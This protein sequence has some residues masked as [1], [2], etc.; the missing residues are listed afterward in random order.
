MNTITA[1]AN[2]KVV[3]ER[4]KGVTHVYDDEGNFLGIIIPQAQADAALYEEAK[5]LFDPKEFERRMREEAGQGITW[6]E[7]QKRLEWLE[8][9]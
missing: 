4:I 9:K 8:S 3:F 1:D 6:D 7:L 2:L 5:R